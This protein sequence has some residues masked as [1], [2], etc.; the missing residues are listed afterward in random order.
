MAGEIAREVF[1]AE[2]A[3]VITDR[4]D[5]H[6]D[7]PLTPVTRHCA[8][9]FAHQAGVALEQHDQ[10]QQLQHTAAHDPLTGVGNRRHADWVLSTLEPGDTVCLLDVDGLKHTND[11]HGHLVGDDIL[12]AV[13]AHLRAGL[14]D[15]DEIARY[16]GDEFLAVLRDV[17]AAHA[18]QLTTRL[19]A[20][21]ADPTGCGVSFSVGTATHT[22]DAGPEHT[23]SKADTA[24]Y[25]VKHQRHTKPDPRSWAKTA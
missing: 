3:W 24:L 13:G 25:A 15:P 4:S 9:L 17:D 2:T 23:L 20:T 7:P 21:W 14:R 6:V 16:G 19:Q 10:H 5:V 1:A 11:T 18:A 12:T 22:A 8:E